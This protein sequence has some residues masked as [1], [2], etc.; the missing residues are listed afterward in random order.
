MSQAALP[1]GSVRRVVLYRHPLPVRLTHWINVLCIAALLP[2][3]LQ[4][5]NAHPALYL[6]QVSRFD[7]PL[8]ALPVFPNWATL[9]D[10][11]DL[12]TGRR[13]HVFFAWLFAANLATMIGFALASGRLARVLAP[14]RADLAQIGPSIIS[15]LRLRFPHGA[16]A[17][18]YN[19]LQKLAYLAIIAALAP[20]MVATGLTMSPA[21]DAAAPWLPT[22]FGG[23]QTARLIH[24]LSAGGI[25]LF[26]A[27]HLAMVLV[28]GLFNNLRSMI[29]GRYVI[30]E[31][32][33]GAAHDRD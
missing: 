30:H 18:R 2:S 8:L 11:Q 21:I 29:T 25:A 5:F 12:A 15:H 7:H 4:I 27:V 22:L 32:G 20:L 3:G 26:I 33:E 6:G 1:D 28:S 14:N 24:F 23:R 9:P 10:F 16:E 17:R 13:W 19:V 31:V